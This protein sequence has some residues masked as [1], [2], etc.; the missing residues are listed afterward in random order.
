MDN[1][2]SFSPATTRPGRLKKKRKKE[3]ISLSCG[4]ESI[5]PQTYYIA[6]FL[7]DTD[8]HDMQLMHFRIKQRDKV[9]TKLNL[10]RNNN[11][12]Y[13]E[14]SNWNVSQQVRNVLYRRITL[15]QMT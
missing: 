5:S 9:L 10:K 6:Y 4:G 7:R 2:E 11:R 15:D 14:F 1:A 3:D 13:R 12:I 8:T